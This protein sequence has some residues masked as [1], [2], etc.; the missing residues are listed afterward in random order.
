[1]FEHRIVKKILFLSLLVYVGYFTSSLLTSKQLHFE[2]RNQIKD[3]LNKFIYHDRTFR[4]D[5]AD[6]PQSAY[7]VVIYNRVAKCGK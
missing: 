2:N 6:V 1:M 3:E 5:V 7:D 4:A